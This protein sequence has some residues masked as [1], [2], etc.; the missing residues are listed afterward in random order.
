IAAVGS[1]K[2]IGS[3]DAR[4]RRV[5]GEQ[6]ELMLDHLEAADGAAELLALADV[7]HRLRE[8]VFES[9]GQLR[10]AH[11]GAVALKGF[12]DQESSRRRGQD[13]RSIPCEGIARLECE[14]HV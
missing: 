7:S 1:A 13:G 6:G 2:R 9:A 11:E 8:E 10:R 14:V 5:A 3:R 4:S 12:W